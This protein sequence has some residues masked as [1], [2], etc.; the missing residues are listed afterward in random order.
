[1]KFSVKIMTKNL[2]LEY[3][4]N[5]VTLTLNGLKA[6]KVYLSFS[7]YFFVMHSE[8]A[9][10]LENVSSFSFPVIFQVFIIRYWYAYCG[11]GYECVIRPIPH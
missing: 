7:S 4:H 1:M 9:R 5:Y 6:K 3:M 8:N 10:C 2:L 11:F